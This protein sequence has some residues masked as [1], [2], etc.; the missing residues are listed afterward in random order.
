[1]QSSTEPPPIRKP[2]AATS[3]RLLRAVVTPGQI[4]DR[5]VALE[6]LVQN[7]ARTLKPPRHTPRP[8]VPATP[9][10]IEAMRLWFLERG[11]TGDAVLVSVLAYVGPRPMEALALSWPDVDRGRVIIRRA[12]SDG[13]FKGTET[14]K[15]RVVEI[16]GPVGMDLLEWRIA[17][18]RR[19]GLI[20]PRRGGEHPWGQADWNN[21]RR[22][23][24]TPAAADAGRGD[25]VPYDLRHSAASL[26]IACGR[27][28]TE[29]A[30]Q[31]GHSPEVSARTYH[32]LL[33]EARG[34]QGRTL[35]EW[36]LEARKKIDPVSL[37]VSQ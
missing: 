25:L 6:I 8:V 4:L 10:E 20:W 36:I 15:H 26:C 5:A 24:F 37:A 31:L 13:C 23:W 34:Q 12:L 18:G 11:R 17:S 32:H 19:E 28:L 33:E 3:W 9:E 27:P 7:P 16:P 35:E 14:G 21:W 2:S 30:H 1:M 22:R 29:V